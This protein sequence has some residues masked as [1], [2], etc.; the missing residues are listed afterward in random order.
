MSHN[1]VI[2]QFEDGH[3]LYGVND[4]GSCYLYRIL[5]SSLSEAE[6][7]MFNPNRPG[8]LE[9]GD[10]AADEE[11]VTLYPGEPWEF[12]TRA[13]RTALWITGPRNSDELLEEQGWDDESIYG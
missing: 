4:G 8:I 13:S 12:L 2:V 6:S 5:F 10:A 3:R 11:N 1:I 9:P 7:W